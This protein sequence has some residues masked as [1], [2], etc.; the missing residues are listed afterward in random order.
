VPI[1]PDQL[2]S[3]EFGF[4]GWF[5]RLGPAGRLREHFRFYG[6]D[7]S[8]REVRWVCSYDTQPQ[9]IDSSSQRSLG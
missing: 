4:V 3:L 7:A 1:S 6:W 8:K 2:V 5:E 9:D